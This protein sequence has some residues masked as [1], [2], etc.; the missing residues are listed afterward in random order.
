MTTIVLQTRSDWGAVPPKSTVPLNWAKVTK[1]IVHY[2]G[3]NRWQ[4]VA[5][6]Q[7]FC[8]VDKGHSDIDYNELVRANVLYVG[9]GLNVGSHTLNNNS[10]SYGV[11]MIGLDGDATSDDL[12]VIRSRYDWACQRAGRVLAKL[13]HNQAPT[14]PAGYTSCPGSQV[15]K[16][17]DAGMPYIQPKVTDMWFLR[18]DKGAIYASNGINTRHMPAETLKTTIEPLQAAGVPLIQ[19]KSTLEVFAAGGPLATDASVDTPTV[20][21]IIFP[22]GTVTL[23]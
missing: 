6:I 20:A 18:D 7:H 1:F 19:Y 14:L 5:S 4:S 11:C 15:Q 8:M 12:N 3:A 13:G 22:P 9:R 21:K 23:E 10:T 17:I 16:W 2:S